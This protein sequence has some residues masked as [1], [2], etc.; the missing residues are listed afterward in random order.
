[1]N[2]FPRSLL[3]RGNEFGSMSMKHTEQQTQWVG[4]NIRLEQQEGR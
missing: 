3:K 1:M 4:H 2:F